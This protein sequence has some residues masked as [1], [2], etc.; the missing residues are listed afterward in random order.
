MSDKRRRFDDQRYCHFV[1]FSCHGRRRF[2]AEDH[3]KRILLGHLNAQL[4]RRSAKCVGFV[5]MP[6]HVHAIV[7]FPEAGQLSQFM[8]QWNRLASFG[9]R[10]WYQEHRPD[11]FRRAGL[12]DRLWTPKYYSFEI[13]SEEKLKE[14]LDYMHMNPGRAGLVE[15]CVDWKW[16]S[17]RWYLENRSVGVRLEWVV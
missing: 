2:L 5:V 4:N 8:Q 15:R 16:S 3:P 10:R 7:W 13:Y 6:D 1:T 11:Y 9:I 17:A 14:K 12:P